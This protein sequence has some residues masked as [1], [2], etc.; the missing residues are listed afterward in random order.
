MWFEVVDADVGVVKLW[1]GAIGTKRNR[2]LQPLRI[3]ALG[4]IAAGMGPTGILARQ[5]RIGDGLRHLE[6][7]IELERGRQLGVEGAAR[8]LDLDLLETVAE[9]SQWPGQLLKA[10]AGPEYSRPRIHVVLHL[11]ADGT[12]ALLAALLIEERSLDP[13]GLIGEEGRH[14]VRADRTHR[15]RVL[16]RGATRGGAQ[17]EAFR[18][19]CRTDPVATLDPDAAALS[20]RL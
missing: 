16:G 17:H 2:V 8:V 10:I 6:H 5:R 1:F 13:L 19:R 12:D 3:I 7:E 14:R 15:A 18:P 11:L 4:K 9:G 20:R